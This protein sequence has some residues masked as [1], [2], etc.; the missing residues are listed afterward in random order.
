MSF[1]HATPLHCKAESSPPVYTAFS[2][3]LSAPVLF[4]FTQLNRPNTKARAAVI[5]LL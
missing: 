2:L 4:A 3:S 5:R 1:V